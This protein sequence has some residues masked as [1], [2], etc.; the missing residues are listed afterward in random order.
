M[1][2]AHIQR[3]SYGDVKLSNLALGA[4]WD[5]CVCVLLACCCESATFSS[6]RMI[7]GLAYTDV[8]DNAILL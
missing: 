2:K 6:H 8:E 3:H 7:I 5:A 4:L 1:I